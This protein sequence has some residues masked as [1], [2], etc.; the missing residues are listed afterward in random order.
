MLATEKQFTLLSKSPVARHY[1]QWNITKREVA[2]FREGNMRE[3]WLN[4][5]PW[6]L[7]LA[8]SAFVTAEEGPPNDS[9]WPTTHQSCRLVGGSLCLC[10]KL[11]LSACPHSETAVD[12]A[13]QFTYKVLAT[14]TWASQIPIEHSQHP[15]MVP[16]IWFVKHTDVQRWQ[17]CPSLISEQLFLPM[18]RNKQDGDGSSSS[19]TNFN[20]ILHPYI[21]RQG[22]FWW[23]PCCKYTN[24]FSLQM[25]SN[26]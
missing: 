9:L 6:E 25:I 21:W 4:P 18:T 19:C 15:I 17:F 22:Y 2:T 16:K 13:E 7:D 24:Q 12:R 1:E 23:T 5:G 3:N 11:S 14:G 10:D 20:L 8:L 26:M